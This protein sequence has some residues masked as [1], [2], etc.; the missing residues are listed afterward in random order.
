[1]GIIWQV[2]WRQEAVTETKRNG[3]V[4]SCQ[5]EPLYLV[6]VC[7]HIVGKCLQF[8]QNLKSWTRNVWFGRCDFFFG[9][10][11]CRIYIGLLYV[12]KLHTI[13]KLC[14]KSGISFIRGHS[15]SIQL[16]NN[17]KCW[18]IFTFFFFRQFLKLLLLCIFSTFSHCIFFS[19]FVAHFFLF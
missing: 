8:M 15:H 13:L 10:M 11:C 4:A 18:K 19:S 17:E 2:C 1:M 14:Y 3:T 9:I 16:L 12:W 7:A 6:L 5:C